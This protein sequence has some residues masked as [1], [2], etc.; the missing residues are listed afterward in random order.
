MVSMYLR[1]LISATPVFALIFSTSAAQA[2][3]P[4]GAVTLFNNVRVFDGKG[5]SLSEPTN[6]L[7][8]GNLIETIS[9]TPIPVDRS[10][11]TTIVD[12]GG[13]TLMPG[14]IDNHWH[15]ML[16]RA[17]PA[18][19]FGDVGYNNLNAGDEAT[20]TLM[21]GFTTIRD[22]GGTGLGLQRAIDQGI[23]KGPRIYP[24]GAM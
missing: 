12:G 19:A 9:P 22:V 16:A 5:T 24:S 20:D 10:A 4:S 8:R 21:R 13:R 7:V 17:T 2:Q 11:T 14:L 3:Q 15:A 6:V 18:Q 1:R 23:V